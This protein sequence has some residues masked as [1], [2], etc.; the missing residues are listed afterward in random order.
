MAIIDCVA[1]QIVNI[2]AFYNAANKHYSLIKYSES[3]HIVYTNIE[4]CQS[5][6]KVLEKL[7]R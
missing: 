7:H 5:I 4:H 6:E 1:G 3:K 2:E